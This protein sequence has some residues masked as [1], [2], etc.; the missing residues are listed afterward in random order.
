MPTSPA[1]VVSPPCPQASSAYRGM[2]NPFSS[3]LADANP[4]PP[5]S[6]DE[7]VH[8]TALD[9]QKMTPMPSR[10]KSVMKTLMM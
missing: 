5:D 10:R 4:E 1:S 2:P 3:G 7:A 6:E 8:M 9:K